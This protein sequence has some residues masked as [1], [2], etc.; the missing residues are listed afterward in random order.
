MLQPDGTEIMIRQVGDEWSR[1]TEDQDGRTIV[2]DKDTGYWVYVA[3]DASGG[4]VTTSCKVGI[5]DVSRMNIP[6]HLRSANSVMRAKRVSKPLSSAKST[7]PTP[8]T[9]G[10][11]K[12]LVLLVA[13]KDK[14]FQYSSSDFDKLFNEKGYSVGGA[15]GS[16]KD[17]Y[18][19][20]SYGQLTVDSIIAGPVTLTN[21]LAYYGADYNGVDI[22][23]RVMV[24]EALGLLAK[25]GFD[26]SQ[27]DSNKDGWCDGFDV[28]HSGYDQAANA[29]PDCI[30]S[31]KWSLYSVATYSG[32]SFFNYHTEAELITRNGHDDITPIGSPCHETGHFLG[33]PDLYDTDYTSSGVGGFCIMSAGSWCDGGLRP[34]HF[35]AWCKVFLG[36]VQPTE[37][38]K[39]G[40]YSLP[41]VEDNAKIFKIKGNLPDN[42]YFLV[43]NRQGCL[44]DSEL[45]GEKRGMLIWHVDDSLIPFI[46]GNTFNT[47]PEHFGVD[48]EEA[49]GT[50][51]LE[52]TSR[53]DEFGDDLDYFRSDTMSSFTSRTMPNSKGYSGIGLGFDIK[54]ISASGDTM[55]FSVSLPGLAI[56]VQ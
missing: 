24:E 49:S 3:R 41:R 52:D 40:Q 8:I 54:N 46:V 4:L 11:M 47:N 51:H 20:V 50:Q 31:H 29:D 22:R 28:I 27:V 34:T 17:Y 38:T 1:Y 43:E 48:L 37:I 7:G 19:E 16:V 2:K 25:T 42:E 18:H 45:P 12:N 39:A 9:S 10:I 30:W 33:L 53:S 13:F 21:D 6:R 56:S 32:V 36:W 55:T 5:T 35:S 15:S 14:P 44:F 26:F 23:P